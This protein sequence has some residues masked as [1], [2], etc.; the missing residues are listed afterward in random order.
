MFETPEDSVFSLVDGDEH[1]RILT[2]PAYRLQRQTE[3]EL[4]SK[5]YLMAMEDYE[6]GKLTSSPYREPISKATWQ[7]LIEAEAI[8]KKMDR[9]FR[10]IVKYQSRKYVDP[11]NHDRRE[12]RMLER[13]KLRWDGAYTVFTGNLSE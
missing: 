4:K 12:A 11:E 1:D 3:G 7:N 2:D 5:V 8:I 9:S 6:M 13:S 10:H